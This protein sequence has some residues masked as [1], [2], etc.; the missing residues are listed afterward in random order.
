MQEDKNHGL[1]PEKQHGGRVK[2]LEAGEVMMER[3]KKRGE[4][5]KAGHLRAGEEVF[6]QYTAK[7]AEVS[8][9]I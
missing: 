5:T 3:F 6:Q 8:I 7:Q 2:A 4:G 1:E 9:Y